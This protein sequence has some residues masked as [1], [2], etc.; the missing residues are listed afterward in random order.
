M[1]RAPCRAL[2]C[3]RVPRFSNPFIVA[4]TKPSTF[5]GNLQMWELDFTLS[6]VQ[7]CFHHTAQV[8]AVFDPEIDF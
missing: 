3:H 5:T 4:A 2:F 1:P 7:Q 8:I 6:L